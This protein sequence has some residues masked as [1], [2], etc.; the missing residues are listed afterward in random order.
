[1]T[2]AKHK[3]IVVQRMKS[4]GVYKP[5]FECAIDTL[6]GI[7]EDKDRN[8]KQWRKDGMEMVIEYTNKG[9]STNKSKSP[10]YLNDLQYNEQILKY[11]KALGLTPIDAI[12]LGVTL[13]EEIDSTAEFEM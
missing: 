11:S 10:Y 6:A 12:R 13:E 3:E 2:K 5:E 9:G 4:L 1:M 8:R 7:L